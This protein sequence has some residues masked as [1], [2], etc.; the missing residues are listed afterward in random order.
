VSG[1]VGKLL[2]ARAKESGVGA[3]TWDRKHGQKFHGR[4]AELLKAM[5]GGGVKLV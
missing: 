1:E 4:T 3:V 2:A 5:Q